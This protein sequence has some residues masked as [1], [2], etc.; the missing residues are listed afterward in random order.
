VNQRVGII[1]SKGNI[2]NDYLYYI[3]SLSDFR[4]YIEVVGCGAV[5]ANISAFDIGKFILQCTTDKTIQ[6]KIAKVLN[7]YDE[8]IEK[9]TTSV[10]SY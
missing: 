8:L 2:N 3:L 6:K 7:N 5:Q 4:R 1:R 9:T 10:S